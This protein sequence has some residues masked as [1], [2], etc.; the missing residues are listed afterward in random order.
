MKKLNFDTERTLRLG[1][2]GVH[3]H[4]WELVYALQGMARCVHPSA[5]EL[6][7]FLLAVQDLVDK[8]VYHDKPPTQPRNVRNRPTEPELKAFRESEEELDRCRWMAQTEPTAEE[9]ESGR[10]LIKEPR[11]RTDDKAAE[12]DDGDPDITFT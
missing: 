7:V 8:V 10:R 11:S 4:Y 1:E 9:L 5:L 6:R 2:E 12:D 3:E